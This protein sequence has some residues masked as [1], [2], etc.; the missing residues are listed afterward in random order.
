[1]HGDR[2][3]QRLPGLK[4]FRGSRPFGRRAKGPGRFVVVGGHLSGDTSL[5][6]A[7]IITVALIVTFPIG[8]ALGLHQDPDAPGPL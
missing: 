5:P 1:M 3:G 8:T 6:A 7:R 4:L 2:H